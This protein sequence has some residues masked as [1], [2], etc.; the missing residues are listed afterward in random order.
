MKQSVKWLNFKYNNSNYTNNIITIKFIIY[1]FKNLQ[2][3]I[4][5]NALRINKIKTLSLKNKKLLYFRMQLD[6]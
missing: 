6:K 5:Q 3:G 2:K 4:F 1:F